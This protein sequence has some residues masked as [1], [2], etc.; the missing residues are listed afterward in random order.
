MSCRN[1]HKGKRPSR[2]TEDELIRLAQARQLESEK[3]KEKAE[4]HRQNQ[5][6]QYL[7]IASPK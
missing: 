1:Q 3:K 4:R 2:P 6:N 5:I 7:A